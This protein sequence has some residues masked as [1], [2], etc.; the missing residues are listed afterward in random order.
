[1]KIPGYSLLELIA[2]GGTTSIYLGIEKS[3]DRK[4][5][6]KILN[7]VDEKELLERFIEE[8][9]IVAS[10]NHKNVISVH[11]IGQIR[12]CHYIAMEYMENGS[13]ADKIKRGMKLRHVFKVMTCIG[14]SLQ[15]IHDRGLVHRDIKPGN[16]LFHKDGTPKLS[17]FGIAKKPDNSQDDT[18]DNFALGSP[19]YVSP[20]FVVGNPVDHK[21]DLYGLGIV[22]Y[23]MITG[24]KPHMEKNHVQTMVAHVEKPVPE[25]PEQFSHYQPFLNKLIAK[26]PK[27]R[28]SSA[29][30]MVNEIRTIQS[31]GTNENSSQSRKKHPRRI[32]S[33]GSF[34]GKLAA[35]VV[36]ATAI[37]GLAT[38]SNQAWIPN[39]QS[40]AKSGIRTIEIE[41]RAPIIPFGKKTPADII[42]AVISKTDD[43]AIH[44][45][46]RSIKQPHGI[47]PENPDLL[48][49]VPKNVLDGQKTASKDHDNLSRD[50][51]PGSQSVLEKKSLEQLLASAKSAMQEYRLTHPAGNSSYDYYQKVLE[52]EPDNQE[53]FEGIKNLT[54][55][56]IALS[57]K[58]LDQRNLK[59]ASVY[60]DRGIALD[61]GNLS[62]MSIGT[63]I[64]EYKKSIKAEG[65][66]RSDDENFRRDLAALEAEFN[67]E[68]AVV[69]SISLCPSPE[70]WNDVWKIL[71][72]EYCPT[73]IS[74]LQARAEVSDRSR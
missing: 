10:L 67:T 71:L 28:Y 65:L 34:S 54:E 47:K 27:N 50:P 63:E 73:S 43:T 42:S 53:A 59:V 19:Y 55:I 8:G 13:L 62:L 58:Q 60:Y 6:I 9:N 36:I 49:K 24:E 12:N 22:F 74:E 57:R 39:L 17:D 32:E 52:I 30:E 68:V 2:T 51:Q 40:Y 1:M 72:G 70:N 61:P 29:R 31:M 3:L 16:I 33:Y 7:K 14:E 41:N 18:L 11:D 5:A 44:I 66:A 20:E 15:Y 46:Y 23:E 69:E 35:S 56:Y 48:Q 25:L 21:A 45:G 64:S 38:V 26:S 4:V 37:G